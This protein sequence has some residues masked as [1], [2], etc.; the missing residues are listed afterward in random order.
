LKY[1]PHHPVATLVQVRS[2]LSKALGALLCGR[3]VEAA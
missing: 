1:D 2:A 3:G